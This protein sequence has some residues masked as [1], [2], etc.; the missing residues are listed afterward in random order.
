MHGHT[1]SHHVMMQS[2]HSNSVRT[3]LGLQLLHEDQ[4]RSNTSLPFDACSPSTVNPVGEQA[5]CFSMYIIASATCTEEHCP[6]SKLS[7]YTLNSSLDTRRRLIEF[8]SCLTRLSL[9]R[10]GSVTRH[11]VHNRVDHPKH[12]RDGLQIVHKNGESVN[13]QRVR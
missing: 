4:F 5:T 13:I 10:R 11:L 12:E 6:L 7:V 9:T 2:P 8:S 3:S 1:R